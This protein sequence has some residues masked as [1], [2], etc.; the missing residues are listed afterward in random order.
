MR[1]KVD[2]TWQ[3]A[4]LAPCRSG[5]PCPIPSRNGPSGAWQPLRCSRRVSPGGRSDKPAQCNRHVTRAGAGLAKPGWQCD[6]GSRGALAPSEVDSGM[7]AAHAKIAQRQ[8][9]PR[10]RPAA[11]AGG[12]SQSGYRQDRAQPD[13]VEVGPLGLAGDEQADLSVHG[14]LSKAVYAYPVEHYPFWQTV[15][16]QAG[17]AP[18]D[19]AAAAGALGENLSIS[20]AARKPG[21]DRRHAALC[22]LRAG[23]Q[24][25]AASP[26]T[27]SMRGW[28][29]TRRQR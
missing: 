10:P 9:R 8:Y 20:R 14:G 1:A 22:R 4:C 27:S 16:S 12:S 13:A 26:A 24:R 15:R 23:G 18:W 28:A 3:P 11:S 2:R 21:L 5:K 29:S 6:D 17:V 19:Q 25:A 7:M